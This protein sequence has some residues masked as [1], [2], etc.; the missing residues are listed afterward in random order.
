MFGTA[1][2]SPGDDWKRWP[3]G[4]Y[5]DLASNAVIQGFVFTAPRS[6]EISTYW[7]AFREGASDC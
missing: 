7:L 1:R 5:P 3:Q 6:G 4:E 2:G